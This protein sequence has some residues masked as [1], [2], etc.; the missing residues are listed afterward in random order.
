MPKTSITIKIDPQRLEGLRNRAAFYRISL[1]ELVR[2]AL[3]NGL[4][5]TL[6]QLATADAATSAQDD[7]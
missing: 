3:D 6:E 4:P 1:A 7:R 2:R 5:M